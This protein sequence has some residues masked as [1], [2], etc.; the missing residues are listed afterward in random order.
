MKV[1]DLGI[2]CLRSVNVSSQQTTGKV[3]K[4]VITHAVHL[5]LAP[6]QVCFR[7]HNILAINVRFI[8]LFL[9]N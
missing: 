5:A 6:D 7:S 8:K 2:F 4:P 1:K 3:E 9:N